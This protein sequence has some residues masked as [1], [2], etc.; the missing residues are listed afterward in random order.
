MSFIL[1][2]VT[3]ILGAVPLVTKPATAAIAALGY[4]LLSWWMYYAVCPSLAYPMWGMVGFSVV[5]CWAVSAIIS[6]MSEDDGAKGNWTSV[7][8]IVGACVLIVTGM[9]GCEAF[10]SS[11]YVALIGNVESKKWTQE[12]QPTDPRHVRL[13]PAELAYYLATKQLGEAPGAIGSQ[14]QIEK[15]TMTLQIIKGELWYV[16]PLEFTGF[17]V[18]TSVGTSPGYVMVNGEDP[19]APV[20]IKLGQKFRY[21]DSAWFGDNVERL[22]WKKYGTRYVLQDFT[23]EIDDSGKAWWTVTALEPTISWWGEKS[24]GLIVID[25]ETGSDTFYAMADVPKWVDRVIPESTIKAYVSYYGEYQ[26]GW[27]NSWWGKLNIFEPEDPLIAF[28][29]DGEPYWI[30]TITSNNKKDKSMVGLIY[31]DCRTGKSVMYHSSG[32]T[33]EAVVDLVNNKVQYRKL[34]GRSSQMYNI[35]GVMTAVVPVLGESHSYQGV[36]FVN[37]G[38]MQVA[39]G[40]DIESALRQYQTT[41]SHTGQQVAPEARRDLQSIEGVVGRFTSETHGDTTMHY[42]YLDGVPHIFVGGVDVSEKLRLTKVGDK[43]KIGYIDSTEDVVPM[44]AFDNP[45]IALVESKNQGEMRKAVD[46]RQTGSQSERETKDLRSRVD[47]MSPEELKKLL[48]AQ[49]KK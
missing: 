6:S 25:P 29:A 40:D 37:V 10:R 14:F 11:R 3:G 16:A 9:A 30:T 2:I 26:S 5:I 34:H 36:A 18:W 15:E 27:V 31:T 4:L 21:I 32:G 46:V 28:G 19:K 17:S 13:V 33:E 8:P 42:V 12:I 7:F 1:A 22:L 20:V 49:S 35:Y 23:F 43:V 45:A 47:N 41:L 39:V 24:V 38:D 44:K 48:E